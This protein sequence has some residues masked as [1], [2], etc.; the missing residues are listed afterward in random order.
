[1]NSLFIGLG[2]SGAKAVAL[3][4]KMLVEHSNRLRSDQTK[5]ALYGELLNAG[6]EFLYIDTDNSILNEFSDIDPKDFFNLGTNAP[7][8]IIKE[9]K[10]SEFKDKSSQLRLLEWVDEGRV[11]VSGTKSL[12]VGADGLRMLSRVVLFQE[13]IRKR[14][15]SLRERLIHKLLQVQE[16]MNVFNNQHA[17]VNLKPRIYV[18]SGSCG[19]TGS[20]ILLDILYLIHNAYKTTANL[21]DK[22]QPLVR[23]VI[24]M[25][26]GYIQELAEVPKKENYRLNAYAFFQELNAV[27]KNY[28]DPKIHQSAFNDFSVVPLENSTGEKFNP[29]QMAFCYDSASKDSSNYEGTAQ[30]LANFI[31]QLEVLSSDLDSNYT[32]IVDSSL[33]NDLTAIIKDS[34]HEKY[35]D[36][37]IV[38]G[39]Y[40][41]IKSDVFIKVYCKYR[42]KHEV[43]QYGIKGADNLELTEKE[44][45]YVIDSYENYLQNEFIQ[46]KDSLT[47]R[48]EGFT[49]NSQKDILNFSEDLAR[50]LEKPQDFSPLDD[51]GKNIIELFKDKLANDTYKLIPEYFR[52]FNLKFAY[53]AFSILDSHFTS[54]VPSDNSNRK[55]EIEKR[56]KKELIFSEKDAKKYKN[57]LID[58][59]FEFY[60]KRHIIEYLSKGDAGVFDIACRTVKKNF[61]QAIFVS[62]WE[63]EFKEVIRNAKNDK[64]CQF[65][66]NLREFV[67]ENSQIVSQNIGEQAFSKILLRGNSGGDQPLIN[68]LFL[69][70]GQGLGVDSYSIADIKNQILQK[71]ADFDSYLNP[72]ETRANFSVVQEDIIKHLNRWVNSEIENHSAIKAFT[73]I[74]IDSLLTNLTKIG[75]TAAEYG[76]LVNN[77][78]NNHTV[79]FQSRNGVVDKQA[80]TVIFGNF[81]NNMQLQRDLG[82]VS[83]GNNQMRLKVVQENVDNDRI[84]KL[85]LEVGYNINDYPFYEKE[86]KPGYKKYMDKY[87]E[88]FQH[89]PFIDRRFVCD[90]LSGN[91]WE[92]F[93]KHLNRKYSASKHSDEDVLNFVPFYLLKTIDQLKKQKKFPES[94]KTSFAFDKAK[95]EFIIN[96]IV[97]NKWNKSYEPCSP[98]KPL[99]LKH[100][101]KFNPNDI[102]GINEVLLP[103]INLITSLKSYI[104]HEYTIFEESRKYMVSLKLKVNDIMLQEFADPEGQ[105]VIKDILEYYKKKFELEAV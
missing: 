14:E 101:Q 50:M 96:S 2:G 85:R 74:P 15:G 93:V 105:T 38:P 104:S 43:L 24:I 51:N 72:L 65:V 59:F 82:A 73:D 10:R 29:F 21:Q 62:N 58:N 63:T 75:M 11:N 40:S 37:F 16:N 76:T 26:H 103:W 91:V 77:F 99:L 97:Y 39:Y 70:N 94:L 33:T 25:P 23:P 102:P 12:E 67:N 8:S 100:S 54:K 56:I 7:Y 3:L 55:N 53:E 83:S 86:Y 48:L 52:N 18:I 79:E 20:G 95:K 81:A 9:T 87:K 31:Y 66:P 19:G 17:G 46:L 69:E 28:Y 60:I 45:I 35:V 68:K 89:Q 84:V 6:D 80:F 98:V 61:D 34:L 27:I 13:C 44:K 90:D 22:D 71:I 49:G 42:I 47:T 36:A 57:Q 88:N 92:Y 4:N 5:V 30:K 32:S 78:R 41:I 1:M 64:S